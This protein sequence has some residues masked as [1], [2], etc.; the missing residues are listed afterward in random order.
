M[1]RAGCR[2]SFDGTGGEEGDHSRWAWFLVT[3]VLLIPA[4]LKYN[5]QACLWN[6]NREYDLG[7]PFPFARKGEHDVG[8]SGAVN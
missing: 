5:E 4:V 7:L 3:S 8:R 1:K 2:L 6:I